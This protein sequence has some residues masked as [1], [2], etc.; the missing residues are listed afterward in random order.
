MICA[1][2]ED[3]LQAAVVELGENADYLVCDVS[4]EAS[5]ASAVETTVERFGRLDCAINSAG[6]GTVGPFVD[7]DS[8][9]FDDCMKTNLYG[10]FYCTR[11]QAKA[12]DTQTPPDAA[13]PDDKA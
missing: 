7:M 5:V 11:A 8:G 13:T 1:R 6:T 10:T 12:M 9:M 2:R 4:D 3:T